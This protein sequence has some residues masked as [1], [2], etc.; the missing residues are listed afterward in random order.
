MT[1][2]LEIAQGVC[3]IVGIPRP[4]SIASTTNPQAVALLSLMNVACENLALRNWPVMYRE[5]TFNTADGTSEYSLPSDFK[6]AIANA[7]Y[8]QDSYNRLRGQHSPENWYYNVI[9]GNFLNSQSYRVA[10]LPTKIKLLPTPT[11]VDSILFPYMST[12]VAEQADGDDISAVTT[13][14]DVPVFDAHL[15]KLD[16]VWRY[17]HQRGFPYNADRSDAIDAIDRV[18]AQALNAPIVNF[19][20]SADSDGITSGFVPERG[21]GA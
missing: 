10:S 5:H 2:A 18:Y 17:R 16:M 3:G 19:G 15:I 14:T 21:F 4:A 8:N 11:A 9:N 12:T 13:D 20:G 1:S 6:R 7:V